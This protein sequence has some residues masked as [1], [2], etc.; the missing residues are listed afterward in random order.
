[1]DRPKSNCGVLM[2]DSLFRSGA[3]TLTTVVTVSGTSPGTRGSILC[4]F[5]TDASQK[6]KTGPSESN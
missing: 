6:T 5:T 4:C 3:L 1:M 2:A